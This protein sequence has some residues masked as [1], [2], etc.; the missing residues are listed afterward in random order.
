VG[1]DPTGAARGD[2]TV[3]GGAPGAIGGALP[4]P[5]RS[6]RRA[7]ARRWWWCTRWPCWVEHRKL[8]APSRRWSTQTRLWSSSSDGRSAA[9]SAPYPLPARRPTGIIIRDATGSSSAPPHREKKEEPEE[10]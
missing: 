5:R 6:S 4:P 7:R 8:Q 10:E 2:V 1:A 9:R 3:V